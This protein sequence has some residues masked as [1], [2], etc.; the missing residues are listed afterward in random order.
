MALTR[1]VAVLSLLLAGCGKDCTAVEGKV[2]GRIES[3]GTSGKWVLTEGNCYSGER[4]GFF[5]VTAEAQDGTDA[6]VIFLKEPVG[7]WVV[8]SRIAGSCSGGKCRFKVFK[9]NDCKTLDVD[10]KLQPA[11]ASQFFDGTATVDCTLDGSHV[12]GTLTMKACRAG[13]R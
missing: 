13:G 12:S 2:S 8:E 4:E 9:K 10:L 11:K 7:G 1:N 3:S 5:G 6:A